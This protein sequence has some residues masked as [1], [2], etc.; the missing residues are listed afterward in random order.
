MFALVAV[1]DHAALR[2]QFP[3]AGIHV[4]YHHVHAQVHG[5]FLGAQ[6]RAQ[7]VVEEYHQQ[8]LVASQVLVSKLVGFHFQCLGYCVMQVAQV[9]YVEECSHMAFCSVPVGRLRV[10]LLPWGVFVVIEYL[11]VDEGRSAALH[12]R[13][14]A[15][16]VALASG[17][18]LP[19]AVDEPLVGG[20]GR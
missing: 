17:T 6:T 18:Y 9:L 20:E 15:G 2:L 3:C 12:S 4:E 10:G 8:R 19:V 1:H 5:R 14:S 7:A 11:W 16:A 13:R